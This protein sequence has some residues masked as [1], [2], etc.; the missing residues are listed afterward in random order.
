[1]KPLALRREKLRKRCAEKKVE[2]FLTFDFSDV[3]YLAGFPSEGCFLL[4]SEAGDFLFAPLLLANHARTR[5]KEDSDLQVVAGQG[6]L[7]E[8]EKI[9]KKNGLKKIGFDPNKVTLSLFQEL[10]RF[11]SAAW[12]PLNGFVLAQR[13]IKDATEIALISKACR[14]TFASAKAA[15]NHLTKGADEQEIAQQ[16][17]NFFRKMGA[18]K[19]AFETIVAFGENSAF[20]HH[21]TSEKKLSQNSVV[22]IDTGCAIE[23][24]RSDL[25]RTSFFG[26]ITF[27]FRKIYSIVKRSQQAGIAA[28][29]AGVSAGK[30]DFNC[31]E[32]IRKQGYGDYFIHGTGHGVGLEIHEPP[33]LGIKSKEILREGMVVTVEPGIYLPGEFGVRI[34]DTVLVK[35]NGCEILTR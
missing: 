28:V 27:K 33:R 23:G 26:K 19:P 3:L 25:T 4:A 34:E 22:L 20:P 24:Y 32:T 29:R 16:L 18:P 14:I 11:R 17:E 21:L 12:V 5:L 30:V 15:M 2:G 7:G 1:M 31:R 8:L 6:L 10:S 9:L 13:A 35:K